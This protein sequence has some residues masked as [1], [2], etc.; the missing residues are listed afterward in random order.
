M[1]LIGDLFME[2]PNVHV[3]SDEGSEY[4]RFH[5]Y[6]ELSRRDEDQFGGIVDSAE[7]FQ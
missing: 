6:S 1:D 3:W 4:Q 5:R 2:G 7:T